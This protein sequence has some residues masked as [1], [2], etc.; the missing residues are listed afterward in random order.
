MAMA[1]HSIVESAGSIWS[2]IANSTVGAPNWMAGWPN[3]VVRTL[4]YSSFIS[5]LE[6]ERIF[7]EGGASIFFAGM[8]EERIS[9]CIFADILFLLIKL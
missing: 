7:A 1:A 9:F 8:A 4:N 3:L 6:C 5:N 2:C